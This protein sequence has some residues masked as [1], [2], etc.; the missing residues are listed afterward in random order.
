MKTHIITYATHADGKFN[1]L[2]NN[3]FGIEVIVLGWGTKW[4]GFN[5]KIIG[6]SNFLD[7]IDDEDIVI[8]LDG[9]DTEIQKPLEDA[10]ER[11]KDMNSKVLLS[12]DFIHNKYVNP[13]WNVF[14]RY[15][16][17]R[18]FSSC[19]KDLYISAGLQMGYT[20][21][22]KILYKEAK[23]YTDEIKDDQVIISKLCKKFDFID[24]DINNN[25]FFNCGNGQNCNN[26]ACF[27]QWPGQM[28]WNR[29]YRAFFEYAKYFIVEYIIIFLIFFSI[30][31]YVSRGKFL[32]N[33]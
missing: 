31:A 15:T 7:T 19:K 9:F 22:L 8:Y 5:D 26:D 20:K 21:Y 12:K 13:L 28:K 25:I 17:N 33:K 27:V 16:T 24:I 11:F 23:K 1:S 14:S 10:I 32:K 2:I 30:I 29:I 18:V 3:K 6:I 4:N